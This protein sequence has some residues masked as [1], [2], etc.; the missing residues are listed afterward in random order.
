MFN[1]HLYSTSFFSY[2]LIN[3]TV[4]VL[5]NPT[6]N[7]VTPVALF[8]DFWSFYFH[9]DDGISFYRNVCE[10]DCKY[11]GYNLSMALVYLPVYNAQ[12]VFINA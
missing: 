10:Y 3:P 6:T 8:F 2:D 9:T 7:L 1:F 11:T 12:K 4:F 5:N